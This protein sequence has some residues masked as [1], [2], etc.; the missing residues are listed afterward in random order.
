MTNVVA[1]DVATRR[2]RA[3]RRRLVSSSDAVDVSYTLEVD[4]EDG[5]DTDAVFES[6]VADLT[7]AVS[8]GDLTES[9]QTSGEGWWGDGSMVN[10]SSST[11]P[12]PPT[13]HLPHTHRHVRR[14]HQCGQF[15]LRGARGLYCGV[16]SVAGTHSRA[17]RGG[18]WGQGGRCG[19]CE[20]RRG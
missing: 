4:V 13:P 12:P 16:P 2:T 11:P 5:A 7:E 15:E 10:G 18:H 17:H 14:Q 19:Q 3:V 9:I 8:S 1:T 20:V 6:L